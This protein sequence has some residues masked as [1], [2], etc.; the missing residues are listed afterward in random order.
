MKEPRIRF[1][2]QEK[3]AILREIDLMGLESVLKKY[4]LNVE[5]LVQWR[6]NLKEPRLA[7]LFS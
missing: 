6:K 5:A 4:T 1:T 7:V 2:T 3:F